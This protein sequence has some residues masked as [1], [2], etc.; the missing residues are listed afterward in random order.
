M[1]LGLTPAAAAAGR[2][3]IIASGL[4]RDI[5]TAGNDLKELY[6]PL[7]SVESYRRFW[8][9][10]NTFIARL[11]R[12]PLVTV[13]AIRGACPAGGCITALACDFR[14]QTEQ[15][16]L[17]LNEVAIG[18]PVP[19]FW[20][21]LFC[22]YTGPG[23]GEALLKTGRL[24]SPP[25]ALELG[26]LDAV[27]P[28]DRLLGAAEAAMAKLLQL[29]D[30]GRIA[31]KTILRQDLSR[32]WEKGWEAEVAPTVAMLKQPQV[33]NVLGAVMQ[34]MSG[35]KKRKAPPSKL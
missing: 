9:A 19:A 25:Q 30:P 3:L 34:R 23:R 18:I 29:P 2:G 11:Y 14:V 27:V 16:T 7:I 13:A 17:G 32:R 12:S 5:F 24:L 15:G 8:G 35:K 31:T 28:K 1:R 26:L 10:Q 4:E 33:A 21:E 6:G 20:M 22:K